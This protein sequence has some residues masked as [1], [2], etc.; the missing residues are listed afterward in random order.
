MDEI[1]NIAG[2]SG[3][4]A[5]IIQIG[6]EMAK[7]LMSSSSREEWEKLF[8]ESLRNFGFADDENSAQ[9]CNCIFYEGHLKE[10]GPLNTQFVGLAGVL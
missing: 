8:K 10:K 7:V 6:R 3:G 4:F 5:L 2:N 1:Q 9:I